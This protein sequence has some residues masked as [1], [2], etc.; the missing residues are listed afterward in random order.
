[1]ERSPAIED[2]VKTWFHAATTGDAS[3]VDLRV[4]SEPG[5]RLIGSDPDEWLSGGEE[6]RTFLRGE[7]EGA[8]GAVM[9]SPAEIEAYEEGSVG[10][11]TARLTITMP[12]GRWVSPRWSAVFAARTTCGGSCRPTHPSPCR[13]TRWGGPTRNAMPT[14]TDRGRWEEED[15]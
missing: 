12:D 8:A 6:I 3:V 14:S 15:L 1:V 13:T 7:V 2:L 9:F 10:W 4:S 5:V 11:A